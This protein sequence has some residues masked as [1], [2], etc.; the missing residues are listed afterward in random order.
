MFIRA[1]GTGRPLDIAMVDVAERLH[2]GVLTRG[3]N[4]VLMTLEAVLDPEGD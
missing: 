2:E 3:E 1:G 4:P